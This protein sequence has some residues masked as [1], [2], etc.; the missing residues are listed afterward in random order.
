MSVALG[1]YMYDEEHKDHG[2][3]PYPL[4]DGDDDPGIVVLPGPA[5]FGTESILTTEDHGTQQKVFDRLPLS[6]STR[7]EFFNWLTTEYAEE[8]RKEE[9]AAQERGEQRKRRRGN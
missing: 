7:R 9:E 8:Q 6:Q 5:K 2:I 1:S 4:S 3:V